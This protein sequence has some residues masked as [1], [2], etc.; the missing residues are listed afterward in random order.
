[1][2]VDVPCTTAL[3]ETSL[4]LQP[5]SASLPLEWSLRAPL[6]KGLAPAEGLAALL[7]VAVILL[8]VLALPPAGVVDFRETESTEG[9]LPGRACDVASLPE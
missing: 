8:T 9:V 4:S 1:M 6:L 5:P 3:D 7:T 2:I